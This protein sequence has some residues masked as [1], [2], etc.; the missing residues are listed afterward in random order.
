MDRGR[1]AIDGDD[2]EEKGDMPWQVDRDP[3]SDL[4]PYQGGQGLCEVRGPM[5]LQP[6]PPRLRSRT[7]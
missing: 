5:G 1:E 7:L 6:G 3:G 4:G 2:E